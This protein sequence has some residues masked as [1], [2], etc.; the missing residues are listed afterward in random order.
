MMW[1]RAGTDSVCV[2]LNILR[3]RVLSTQVRSQLRRKLSALE[4]Y[5]SHRLAIY[6]TKLM[7]RQYGNV[8]R[9]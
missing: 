8:F 3:A 6:A 7:L 4:F 5:V 1:Q 9:F 2:R